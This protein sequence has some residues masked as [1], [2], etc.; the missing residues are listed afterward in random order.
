MIHAHTGTI[1]VVDDSPANIR[2]L[3]DMLTQ[4]GHTVYSA[5]DGLL[6][7]RMIK[8]VQP[9][10]VLLD[11]VM[12]GMD[13]FKVCQFLKAGVDTRDIQVVFMTS[14]ADTSDK[15]RG[16]RLGAADY[17]TKPF[18][19]EEV[20]AR[21][22]TLL[23]LHALRKQ[24]VV[25]NA[26]LV[27]SNRELASLNDA[28]AS[29]IAEHR[30]VEIA[31]HESEEQLRTLINA[32][33]D[34]VA[35][36]DGEGRWLEANEFD[37]KLFQLE[38]VDYHGKKDSELAAFS[39]FYHDAFLLC[40]ESDELAWEARVAVR[41][42]EAI[43]RPAGPP[44]VFDVI[45]VPMFHVDGQRKGLVVVGR[46]ITERKR[47]EAELKRYQEQLEHLVDERT[48]ELAQANSRLQAEVAERKH[49]EELVKASL[50]EKEVLLKEVHHR[51]KNNLQIISTLLDLQ[52]ESIH[53]DQALK[54][55]RDS[56]DR[57]KAMALI[58]ER[59]YRSRDL[60]SID[61]AEYVNNLAGFLFHSYVQDPEQISLRTDVG[62]V[63]LEIDEAIPCGLII[64]E[65]ITNCLKHGFPEGRKGEIAIICHVGSNGLVTLEVAD[66][67]IGLPAGFDL[68]T[69][70][71]LGLQ[72]VA[73]L[74]RQLRGSVEMRSCNGASFII[75]FASNSRG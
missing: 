71:S 27:R 32:M 64:N 10:L 6:A 55:F 15:V 72:I 21:V 25:Q 3:S 56:Q 45:K 14:L 40:E 69:A 59:L 4:R 51:V 22:D 48:S 49:A 53:D 65:L 67:G 23:S 38:G 2:L 63:V 75:S 28:L 9:D 24:L 36:K 74:V 5:D 41:A 62:D 44:M 35:F 19:S 16:F 52:T 33:P 30:K 42:D 18:Q 39:P 13:G 1:L 54:S 29:Q 57:I 26:E 17:I 60:A 11:V 43:P 47:V 31:L 8:T 66:T 61:F 50:A 73:M 34:I 12:P 37:L 58:H 46:D 20:L 7:L 68:R 70:G